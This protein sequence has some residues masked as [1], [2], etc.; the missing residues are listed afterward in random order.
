MSEYRLVYVNRK[1]DNM[2]RYS[3]NWKTNEELLER[4]LSNMGLVSPNVVDQGDLVEVF[5][6]TQLGRLRM[7]RLEKVMRRFGLHL[8]KVEV[9]D[10][11]VLITFVKGFRTRWYDYL[12]LVGIT[13][14]NF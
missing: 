3:R 2:L 14:Q 1:L 9:L 10:N 8:G 12:E 7:Y 11:E 6:Q 13:Q 4:L 5:T